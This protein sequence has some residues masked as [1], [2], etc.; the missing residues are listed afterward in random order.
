MQTIL[1]RVVMCWDNE[2]KIVDVIDNDITVHINRSV[3]FHNI[4]HNQF[5]ATDLSLCL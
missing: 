4:Y 5:S 3:T 1:Y 2:G